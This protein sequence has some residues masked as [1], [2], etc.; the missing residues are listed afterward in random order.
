MA[1]LVTGLFKTRS[2]AEHAVESLVDDGFSRDDISLLMSD[3]T[4]GREFS[5]QMATKAPEGVATGATVGG[6][7]GAIA[8]GLVALGI[9]VVPGLALVAAGPIIATLAGLGAG[10]AAGG[11]AGGLI[12]LGLPEHEARFYSEEIEKGGILVG[13]YSH[14]DRSDQAHRILEEAGADKVK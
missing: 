13:V 5:L 2:G 14:D 8:A 6:V 10:A 3:A 7:L 4:R 1:T 12:G 11:L 9:V